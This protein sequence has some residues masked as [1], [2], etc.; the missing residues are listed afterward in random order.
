MLDSQ[1]RTTP[2]SG[3]SIV[4]S[5]HTIEAPSP[6]VLN[7]EV[8]IFESWSDGGGASHR[9]TVT[10]NDATYTATFVVES[11]SDGNPGRPWSLVG[12]SARRLP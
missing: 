8:Y 5:T 1:P 10:G 2:A 3:K 7:G 11:E 6:Q 4:G 9:I 12:A